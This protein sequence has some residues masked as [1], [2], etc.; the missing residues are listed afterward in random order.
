MNRNKQLFW[1]NGHLFS[2]V[3]KPTLAPVRISICKHTLLFGFYKSILWKHAGQF[4]LVCIS[5]EW[6]F[7]AWVAR[8]RTWYHLRSFI[9]YMMRFRFRL[10]LPV[11]RS[12]W[13]QRKPSGNS[14]AIR[15]W[16]SP[17]RLWPPVMGVLRFC[18]SFGIELSAFFSCF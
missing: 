16:P 8:K 18:S 2:P 10:Q 12:S 15:V 6:I 14:E 13:L 17:L 5:C 9:A 7:H 1:C 4:P 11:A 3:P